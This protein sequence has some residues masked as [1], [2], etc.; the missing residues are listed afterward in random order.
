MISNIAAHTRRLFLGA[1]APV[2]AAV[3][4]GPAVI[5]IAVVGDSLAAGCPFRTLSCRRFK[6][7]N[8]AKGGARLADIAGQ[9]ERAQRNGARRFIIDGGLNDLLSAAPIRDIE[10]DFRGVLQVLDPG[11]SAI[12][13]LM[14][15][16]AQKDAASRIDAANAMMT[17]L[18]RDRGVVALDL[19]PQ[20]SLNGVRR[21]EMSDDGLHFTPRANAVWIAAIREKLSDQLLLE[22]NA[23]L[24]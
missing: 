19:N 4:P 3:A 15:Y 6:V 11:A 22:T 16:V 1:I 24:S 7:I 5:S 2:V 10:R 17:E 23:N 8:L 12:F 9:L 14:P 18:C 21:A 13:T 20:V